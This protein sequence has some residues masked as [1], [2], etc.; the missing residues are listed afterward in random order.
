MNKIL[1]IFFLVAFSVT[2]VACEKFSLNEG[3]KNLEVTKGNSNFAFDIFRELNN[4]DYNENIFISP[5]S[6]SSALAMTLNGAAGDTKTAMEETLKLS[7]VSTVDINN[8]F[9]YLNY[10]LTNRDEGV[11]IKIANSLWV[12]D[13]F[14]L[15][16]QFRIDSRYNYDAS[17]SDLDFDDEKSLEVINKWVSK[18]T[19]K[20][21]DEIIEEVNPLAALY[22]LNAI[23]FNGTW[24]NE[25]DPNFTR[26]KDF[27]TVNGNV[28]EVE[29][30]RNSSENFSYYEDEEIKAIKLPYGDGEV[31]M[32]CILPKGNNEINSVI[33]LM[34]EERWTEVRDSMSSK[35][36]I[37][38]ELPKFKIEYGIKELNSALENLGM[39]IAFDRTLA[40]FP[41]LGE[42]MG[43]L[44]FI[45]KVIHKA[46]VEVTEK[47]TEAAGATGVEVELECEKVKREFIADKPF[48]FI[49][50]DDE[51]NILFI[52]K[53]VK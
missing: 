35:F 43:D 41:N 48:I 33:S 50:G 22:L 11:E 28:I 47:G 34:N 42:G 10:S 9:A 16:E 45:K 4:E 15:N 52:G 40:E 37:I 8:G 6:I 36:E 27:N 39:Q 12:N 13:K 18:K 3:V 7:E 53:K 19:S 21:I 1:A 14:T 20:K 46:V 17:V 51:G 24:Q 5:Y 25:F 23:Y 29:M 30:M 26:V 31:S 2:L 49:I 44:L 38:L 32:Y